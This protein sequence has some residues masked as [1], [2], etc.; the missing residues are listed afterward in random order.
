MINLKSLKSEIQKNREQFK[1]E[2]PL[3]KD[4]INT[5]RDDLSILSIS[6]IIK[7][8]DLLERD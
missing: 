4:D 3:D 5:F 7:I 2:L 6:T 1:N 8:F